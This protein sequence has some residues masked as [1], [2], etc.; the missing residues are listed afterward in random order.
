[1]FAKITRCTAQKMGDALRRPRSD[2][3]SEGLSVLGPTG[4]LWRDR[5]SAFDPIAE[6]PE[7]RNKGLGPQLPAGREIGGEIV[8]WG[9]FHFRVLQLANT[10]FV[11]LD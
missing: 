6:R 8:I 2:R 9:R 4:G 5:H 1:M 11:L 3:E 10:V 7:S